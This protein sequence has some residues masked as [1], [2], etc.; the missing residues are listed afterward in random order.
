[1]KQMKTQENEDN[2]ETAANYEQDENK[3]VKASSVPDT[4]QVWQGCMQ[5]GGPSVW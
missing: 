2:E 3:T 5:Q 4:W 1:M